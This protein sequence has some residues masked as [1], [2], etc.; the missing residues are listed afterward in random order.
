MYNFLTFIFYE[1]QGFRVYLFIH[2]GAKRLAMIE[3][4]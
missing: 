1:S 3:P 2:T 4:L